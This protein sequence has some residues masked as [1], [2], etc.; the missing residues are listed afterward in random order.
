MQPF[1][2][3]SC[4]PKAP[5]FLLTCLTRR[6]SDSQE[7]ETLQSSISCIRCEDETSILTSY[8]TGRNCLRRICSS[9]SATDRSLN[10]MAKPPKKGSAEEAKETEEA[11]K[12]RKAA[13][14]LKNSIGKMG[15]SA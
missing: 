2:L 13:E 15:S 11:K 8:P 3:A 6:M 5:V 4:E 14:A 1:L 10:R 12:A 9:C 7:Q